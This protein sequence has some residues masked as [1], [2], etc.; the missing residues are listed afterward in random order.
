M[1]S[2]RLSDAAW[3]RCEIGSLQV[4]MRLPPCFVVIVHEGSLVRDSTYRNRRHFFLYFRTQPLGCCCSRGADRSTDETPRRISIRRTR[5]G[6][7]GSSRSI[8][9]SISVFDFLRG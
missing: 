4:T 3:P 5:H 7:S 9:R 6:R 1:T 8:G 2:E